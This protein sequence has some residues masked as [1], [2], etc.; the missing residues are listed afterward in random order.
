MDPA[1]AKELQDDEQRE[2][3]PETAIRTMI[4]GELID[5]HTSMPGI[6]KSFDAKTQTATVQPAI[7]RFFVGRGYVSLPQCVD[8]PV[9]FPRYGNFVI[10]GPV[11]PGDEAAVVLR[12]L[13]RQLVDHRRRAGPSRAAHA[14]PVG[15]LL[16]P[17]V[18]VEGTRAGEHRERCAGDS[19]A[20]WDNGHPPEGRRVIFGST[21]PPSPLQE[22]SSTSWRSTRRGSRTPIETGNTRRS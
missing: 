17:R 6:V 14:R 18:F 2:E 22:G 1:R 10:T 9:S 19:D 20:G 15:R 4:E 5:V 7:R 11:S 8:V 3:S 16:H 13:H 12:A 21:A